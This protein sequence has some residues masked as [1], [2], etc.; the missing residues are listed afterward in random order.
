MT[1]NSDV[2]QQPSCTTITNSPFGSSATATPNCTTEDTKTLG[3]TTFKLPLTSA[4]RVSESK[5]VIY[6][7]KECRTIKTADDQQQCIHV[8]NSQTDAMK[9][10]L[11]LSKEGNTSAKYELAQLIFK[12]TEQPYMQLGDVLAMIQQ[13]EKVNQ[14]QLFQYAMKLLSYAADHGNGKAQEQ[15]MHFDNEHILV[16]PED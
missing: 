11:Q 14:D 3:K 1:E 9:T 7:R 13:S 15:L 2:L 10:L 5:H 6:D 12:A 4:E 8:M 16:I